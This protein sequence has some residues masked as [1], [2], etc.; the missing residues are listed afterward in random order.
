VEEQS[1]PAKRE[2]HSP[3]GPLGVGIALLG[4]PVVVWILHPVL[5]EIIAALDARVSVHVAQVPPPRGTR[6]PL[7]GR[8][9][10]GQARSARVRRG[11]AQRVPVGPPI[12]GPPQTPT[13]PQVSSTAS[14][15]PG[16]A[17]RYA[18]L[19]TPQPDQTALS[20]PSHE[21]HP[22]SG[23]LVP[24]RRAAWL[25]PF[26]SSTAANVAGGIIV[27]IVIALTTYLLAHHASRTAVRQPPTSPSATA[28]AH[29]WSP[30]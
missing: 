5:S 21:G 24:K 18:K 28:A 17:A 12:G 19:S 14:C 23:G 22:E 13:R 30:S 20:D 3:W 29:T 27:A 16:R 2:Q 7:T 8:R 1:A 10:R 15:C 4:T 26:L 9:V 6:S 25:G 11:D